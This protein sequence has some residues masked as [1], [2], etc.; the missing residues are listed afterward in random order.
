MG[1]KFPSPVSGVGHQDSS[2][3]LMLGFDLRIRIPGHGQGHQS[4]APVPCVGFLGQLV[5]TVVS[6]IMSLCHQVISPISDV[7]S[8]GLGMVLDIR[9]Q[10]RS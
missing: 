9:L 10:A 8:S 6:G 5:L 4:L 1:D 3:C 2:R 7:E